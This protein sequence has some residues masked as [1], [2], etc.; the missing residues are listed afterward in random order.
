VDGRVVSS[1]VVRKHHV[2][3]HNGYNCTYNYITMH[4]AINVKCVRYNRYIIILDFTIQIIVISNNNK[5]PKY[6]NL[7]EI[8]LPPVI[9]V[10]IF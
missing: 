5:D 3:R 7:Y 9:D 6:Q 1:D 8:L 2:T 10:K 4:G